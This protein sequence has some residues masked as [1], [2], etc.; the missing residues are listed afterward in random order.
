M[1]WEKAWG[2]LN[3][4]KIGFMGYT[5]HKK[6]GKHGRATQTDSITP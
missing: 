3:K 2:T 4:V 5:L 6:T 1:N